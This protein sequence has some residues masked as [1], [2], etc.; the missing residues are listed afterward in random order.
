MSTGADYIIRKDKQ[1]EGKP[2]M[3]HTL[4]TDEALN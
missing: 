3:G 4:L 1:K 2:F